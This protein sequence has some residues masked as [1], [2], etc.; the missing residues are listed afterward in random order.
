MIISKEEHIN[1][2][3]PKII[4]SR[5]NSLVKKIR[6]LTINQGRKEHGMILLEGTHLLLEALKTTHCIKEVIATSDWIKC[7]KEIY[8]SIDP[9]TC[10]HE[11]TESVLKAAL[12]TKNPDGVA[13]IYPLT[14]LPQSSQSPNFVLALDRLQDPG[15]LGTL[16]RTALAADVELV[17]LASGADPLSQKALRATSG[18]IFHMPYERLGENED[19]SVRKLSQRL[20]LASERGY[21]IVATSVPSDEHSDVAMPYWDLDWRK[22]TILVLGNEGSGI[23]STIKAVCTHKITLPHNESVE[24]LNVASA[25]VPLL[26]E[27]R[28]A[29]MTYK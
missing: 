12:T 24:S 15:N 5:R 29:K 20:L 21:Q 27:R 1:I 10:I 23:N 6:K 2:F 26:L 18:A 22:N 14:G 4:S 11:V 16:F 3:E 9:R 7:N 25:A 19:D 13:A 28:R 17:L 8:D